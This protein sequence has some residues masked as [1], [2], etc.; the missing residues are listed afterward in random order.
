M[1]LYLNNFSEKGIGFQYIAYSHDKK[2]MILVGIYRIASFKISSRNHLFIITVSG[3]LFSFLQTHL[4]FE[5]MVLHSIYSP[6]FLLNSRYLH[7][8]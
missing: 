7:K 3:I 6:L 4:L 2:C 1:T 8:F 5:Y